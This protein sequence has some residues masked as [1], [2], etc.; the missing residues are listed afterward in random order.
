[1]ITPEQEKKLRFKIDEMNAK[2][3]TEYVYLK[4]VQITQRV[5]M[6]ANTQ[7]VTY[8]DVLSELNMIE[9]QL[10]DDEIENTW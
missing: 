4:V 8:K 1:M 10:K 7:D 5:N 3:F 6:I 2:Y 9:D